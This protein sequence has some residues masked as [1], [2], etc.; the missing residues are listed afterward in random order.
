MGG[1]VCCAPCPGVGWCLPVRHGFLLLPLSAK[2][3]EKSELFIIHALCS[4]PE[5][6]RDPRTINERERRVDEGGWRLLD[7]GDKDLKRLHSMTMPTALIQDKAVDMFNHRFERWH[8]VIAVPSQSYYGTAEGTVHTFCQPGSDPP[9]VKE[10][11]SPLLRRGYN[12]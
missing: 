3:H 5:K 1:W 12:L 2:S 4:A 11:P 8:E 10:S 6:L 7:K 9:D